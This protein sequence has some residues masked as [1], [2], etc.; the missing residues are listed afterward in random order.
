MLATLQEAISAPHPAEVGTITALHAPSQVLTKAEGYRDLFLFWADLRRRLSLPATSV[1]TTR[2]LE[3]RDIATLDLGVL[4]DRAG[5]RCAARVDASATTQDW[6][7]A[8]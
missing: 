6:Y 2:M 1:E 8:G 7:G 5:G 3:S 4:E